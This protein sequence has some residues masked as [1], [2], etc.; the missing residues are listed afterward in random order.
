MKRPAHRRT[1]CPSRPNPILPFCLLDPKTGCLIGK[2]ATGGFRWVGTGK[3]ATRAAA[4]RAGF[5]VTARPR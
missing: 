2:R 4:K 3:P 1:K 5:H